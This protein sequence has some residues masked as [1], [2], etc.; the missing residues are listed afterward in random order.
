[1]G[2]PPDPADA[3]RGVPAG[4]LLRDGFSSVVGFEANLTIK[5]WEKTVTPPGLDGGDAVELTTM[6]NSVWR[7][8]GPRNLIT[9]TEMSLVAAYDPDL[10]DEIVEI[11]NVATTVTVKFAD[12]ST[13]AFFGFLQKF[14]PSDLTEGEQPECTITIMPTNLDPSDFSEQGPVLTDV[15]GT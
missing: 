4:L 10:Y 8:F 2:S 6:H 9:L 11:I 3:V 1:M 5:F 7:G 13:L 15:T 12:T 14:E